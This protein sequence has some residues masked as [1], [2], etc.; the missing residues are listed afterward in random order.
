MENR[1]VNFP[2][3]NERPESPQLVMPKDKFMQEV[4]ADV[5]K[6][7]PE[8]AQ[9]LARMAIE[10]EQSF[11]LRN[12][13]RRHVAIVIGAALLLTLAGVAAIYAF[14]EQSKGAQY[15]QVAASVLLSLVGFWAVFRGRTS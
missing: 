5:A 12:L 1:V 4:L 13:L 2:R 6:T 8:D 15:V 9:V 3:R 14:G 10:R 11:E 7:R